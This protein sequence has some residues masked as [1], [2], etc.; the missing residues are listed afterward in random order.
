ML[1]LHG[2]VYTDTD[3]ACVRPI[4]EWLAQ[5]HAPTKFPLLSALPE[6]VRLANSAPIGK[7]DDEPSLLVSVEF[8]GNGQDWRGMGL[9][10]GLQVVQWT[11]LAKQG[12]PVLLD[13]M[14]KALRVARKVREA[15]ADG[16]TV[17]Q[18]DVVW[19]PPCVSPSSEADD[20]GSWTGLAQ[21]HCGFL[22]Q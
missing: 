11:L 12:H 17:V 2:G 21:E 16:T 19:H 14:G 13:V 6:L 20:H 8:D 4:A 5:V 1:F 22:V 9:A 7:T 3:T 10:R 18:M 15:E